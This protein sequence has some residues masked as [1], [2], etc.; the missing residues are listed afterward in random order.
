MVHYLQLLLEILTSLYHEIFVSALLNWM[1]I[2]HGVILASAAP[3][4]SQTPYSKGQ[5]LGR[6]ESGNNKRQRSRKIRT[7]LG[8]GTLVSGCAGTLSIG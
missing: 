7:A 5:V 4:T 2:R 3:W 6:G 1:V 8:D